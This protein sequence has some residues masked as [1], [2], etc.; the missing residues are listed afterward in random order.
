MGKITKIRRTRTLAPPPKDD[1]V[2]APP[3]RCRA[4][5][6]ELQVD[7]Q[8]GKYLVMKC[9]KCGLNYRYFPPEPLA[10]FHDDEEED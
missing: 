2:S 5:G 4:C 7:T 1:G 3:T 6:I 8:V 9:P 10:I